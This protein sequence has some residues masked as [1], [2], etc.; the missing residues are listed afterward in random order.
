M[1]LIGPLILGFGGAALLIW[2]GL[3]QL[4][5]LE[6]KERVLAEMDARIGAAPGAVPANPMPAD[7]YL[8]V[9]IDC[10]LG[11][12]ELHV[13]TSLRGRGPG[14]R[15]IVP[16][17]TDGRVILADLGF[18]AE[19]DKNA[20][21]AWGA[22]RIGG[23]LLWPDEIDAWFTPDPDRAA[24]VWFARDLPAMAQA[25]ESEPVLVVARTVEGAVPPTALMPV[26]TA[27]IPNDHREY[28]ITWFSMAALWLGMTA[29]LVWRITR[30]TE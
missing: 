20:E 27:A 25:L 23:N 12:Q 13:L 11:P 4:A 10:A 18:V 17:R 22:A 14:Y 29:L 24:N 2:L 5:R 8:A 9:A 3:W 21:R 15:L 19:A 30:R 16:C 26:D 1:R 7:A 6:W 28:A